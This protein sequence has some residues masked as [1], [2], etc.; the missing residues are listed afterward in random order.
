MLDT[1]VE[2][3]GFG[4]AMFLFC[5]DEMMRRSQIITT[6]ALNW[7]T[8]KALQ[9]NQNTTLF[10]IFELIV[11]R[12]VDFVRASMAQRSVHVHVPLPA[13]DASLDLTPTPEPEGVV[14][15]ATGESS[16]AAAPA[17]NAAM[18]GAEGSTS[19]TGANASIAE[20]LEEVDYNEDVDAA[21]EQRQGKRQ[22]QGEGED[23]EGGEGDEMKAEGGAAAAQEEQQEQQALETTQDQVWLTTEALK[24]AIGNI[25]TVYG[26]V[27]STLSKGMAAV[28]AQPHAPGNGLWYVVA[29][30]LLLKTLRAVHG[31][32]RNLAQTYQRPVLLSDVSHKVAL[33]LEG[34][35]AVKEIWN[36]HFKV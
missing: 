22:R 10:T 9:L 29:Q 7:T 8:P 31:A 1:L 30:S 36:E 2:A 11:D 16:S 33:Y 3:Y 21:A 35:G 27:L 20:E 13:L 24:T 34:S 5:L 4:S 18:E 19:S 23:E 14:A 28:Q 12:S 17:A 6:A 15:M 26:S 25:R 32:E